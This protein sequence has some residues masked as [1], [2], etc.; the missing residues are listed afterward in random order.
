M[1]DISGLFSRNRVSQFTKETRREDRQTQ[2]QKP[3]PPT[4]GFC[5]GVEAFTGQD[6]TR[7]TGSQ[8]PS[9][10][11]TLWTHEQEGLSRIRSY[12]ILARH[13]VMLKADQVHTRRLVTG[14]PQ[15][16]QAVNGQV[17]RGTG[18]WNQPNCLIH[19][20][21]PGFISWFHLLAL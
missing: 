20:D 21:C 15:R 5:Q 2:T 17:L 12:Q 8:L 1:Q 16:Q 7:F 6:C 18:K 19:L 14:W 11:Q 10:P 9:F 4:G 3:G 13:G